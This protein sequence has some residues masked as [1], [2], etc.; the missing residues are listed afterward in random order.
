MLEQCVKQRLEEMGLG[1][2]SLTVNGSSV[3]IVFKTTPQNA[4]A[5]GDAII[6]ALCEC[7]AGTYSVTGEDESTL[8]VV[9]YQAQG[10]CG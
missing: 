10:G 1:S 4:D 5:Q 6:N 8:N 9:L 7:G 3:T 2:A